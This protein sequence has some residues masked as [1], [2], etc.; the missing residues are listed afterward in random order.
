[1]AIA[2]WRSLF[3]RLSKTFKGNNLRSLAQS[4]NVNPSQ[5][6]IACSLT[7][8]Y[9]VLLHNSKIIHMKENFEAIDIELPDNILK[10]SSY[11]EEGYA[12]HPQHIIH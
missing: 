10:K 3:C 6:L 9:I 5:L 8:G 7:K 2:L 1:M 12:T 4:I 11:L